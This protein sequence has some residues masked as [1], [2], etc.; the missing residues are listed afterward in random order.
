MIKLFAMDVDGTLTDGRINISNNGELFKSFNVK[1]GLGIRLLIENNI[2]PVIIT[3]RESKIVEFRMN[4]LEIKY[5][6]QN[7]KNKLYCLQNICNDLNIKLSEVA[8]IGDDINDIE[9]L[10]NVGYSFCPADSVEEVKKIANY[11]CCL[12]GG[13]GAVRESI[14][15]ILKESK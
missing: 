2:I 5:I 6:Y 15:Y 13:Q 8:Y 9:L 11:I 3:G 4:E 10:K 14:N 12:S 7:I 1:D